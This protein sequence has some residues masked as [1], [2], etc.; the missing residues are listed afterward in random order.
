MLFSRI[1][2]LVAVSAVTVA[3]LPSPDNG[4]VSKPC[5]KH[6]RAVGELVDA[7][8]ERRHDLAARR[9]GIN[10]DL[11]SL[12]RH[13]HKARGASAVDPLDD[14]TKKMQALRPKVAD[15]M[16]GPKEERESKL[17]AIT[18]DVIGVLEAC[19]QRIEANASQYK[20]SDP[21][22]ADEMDK[23]SKAMI[24]VV[25]SCKGQH[26]AEI[27]KNIGSI[28]YISTILVLRHGPLL[29]PSVSNSDVMGAIETA[30]GEKVDS[31]LD[32]SA[33]PTTWAINTGKLSII[34]AGL[35]A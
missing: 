8:I 14:A 4:T 11:S 32:G 20:L 1:I 29:T 26:S 5:D 22:I 17:L 33:S 23:M 28:R 6:P 30:M 7:G 31:K 12:P 3:A 19:R 13:G 9:K 21:K 16:A 35:T 15:A 27:A 18:V 34:Q 2:A 25:R 10:P 24:R